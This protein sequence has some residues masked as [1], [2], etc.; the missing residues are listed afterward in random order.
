MTTEN[1]TAVTEFYRGNSDLADYLEKVNI[2]S[3][4]AAFPIFLVIGLAGNTLS[5][6][7]LRR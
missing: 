1:I 6:L 4:K 3:W 5:I 2:L 7:V